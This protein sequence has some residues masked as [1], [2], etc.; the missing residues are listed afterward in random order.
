[1]DERGLETDDVGDEAFEVCDRLIFFGGGGCGV[2]A[3]DEALGM[4]G[5]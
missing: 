3:T 5:R 2:S 4:E 1:M